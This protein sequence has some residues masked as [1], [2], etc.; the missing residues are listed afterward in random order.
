[1]SCFFTRLKSVMNGW[2]DE[3]MNEKRTDRM[4]CHSQTY[5]GWDKNR[6]FLNF[7]TTPQ[8][9]KFIFFMSFSHPSDPNFCWC[10]LFA[11]KTTNCCFCY[12][13]LRNKYRLQINF[14]PSKKR[15]KLKIEVNKLVGRF[16]SS[17]KVFVL[18]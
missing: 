4:L 2:M 12:S 8:K 7:L 14:L 16:D 17:W 5:K 13:T 1:M 9:G 3:W 10:F 15:I 6:K 11:K 18:V